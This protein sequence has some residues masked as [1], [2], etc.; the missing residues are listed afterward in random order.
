MQYASI[1]QCEL[2]VVFSNKMYTNSLP[3]SFEKLY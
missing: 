3:F 2:D 1:V